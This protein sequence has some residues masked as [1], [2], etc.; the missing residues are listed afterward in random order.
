[1]AYEIDN[2]FPYGCLAAKFKIFQLAV[3]ER[4]P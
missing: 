3:F 4:R 2:V 1:M